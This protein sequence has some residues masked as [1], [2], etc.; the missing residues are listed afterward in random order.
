M[1]E[2]NEMKKKNTKNLFIYLV[3]ETLLPVSAF[4]ELQ[5]VEKSPMCHFIIWQQY[6]Q[7]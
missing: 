3:S 4:A 7:R 5:E 6:T 2:T 1:N